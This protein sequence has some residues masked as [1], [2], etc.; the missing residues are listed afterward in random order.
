MAKKRDD[1]YP[2]TKELIVDLESLL[3][4]EPPLMARKKYDQRLLQNLAESGTT[5]FTPTAQD[6]RQDDARNPVWMWVVVLAI[7][8][9][10]SLL[11]NIVLLAK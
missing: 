4:G 11:L 3:R 7:G 2:S 6:L 9:L 1:R 5:V 8:L 10:L